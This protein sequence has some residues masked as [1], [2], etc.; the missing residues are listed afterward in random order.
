[1]A[2]AQQKSVPVQLRA[3][4]TVQPSESVTVR[5]RVNGTLLK[6]HFK[7]GQDVREGDLL[8]TIDD[9]QIQA[10][11][12]QAE[13][14]L[15]KSTAELD[16]A[17]REAKRYEELVR[18]GFVA[19]SQY[20][21]LQTRVRSLEATVNADRALVQNARVGAGYAKIRAP[22]AGRTGAVPVHEGDLVAQN[23]TALVVINELAPIDVGF[24]LSEREL[25]AVQRYRGERGEL[26]ADAT[27]AKSGEP[28]AK[29]TLTFI[30]NRVDPATGTIQIKAT[31]ANDP[32]TLWPGQFVNVVLTLATEPA[33]VVP[34]PAVQTGQQGRYVFVVKPD[35]T[36][37]SRPV[38]AGRE[39][40]GDIVVAKG[41]NAG[42]TV[43]TE[44]QLRLFPGAKVQAQGEA[45]AASPPTAPP[46]R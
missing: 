26:V 34:S 41:V 42:E 38:E 16:N 46:A 4:G 37:E 35:G 32:I 39:F 6:I 40:G 44:G 36:V 29:G 11:V 9:R 31:F 21:Q 43:V 33:I 8:F 17:R 12:R 15:G 7:E 22:I 20:D 19:Q 18:K 1:V 10:E 24:A 5:S 30:D 28:I 27:Q 25:P 23:Q 14:N 3:I 45:A 2:T 13:A